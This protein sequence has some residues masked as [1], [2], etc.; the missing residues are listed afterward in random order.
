MKKCLVISF[1]LGERRK[2]PKIYDEDRLVLIKKQIHF[3]EKIKHDLTTIVFSFNLRYEDIDTFNQHINLIP[4][5]IQNSDVEIVL[6][7]NNGMSYGAWSEYTVKNIEKYDYFIYNEDDYFFIQD[8]F[9]EYLTNTFD[10]YENC[11]YLCSISRIPAGWNGFRKHAG[12]AGGI[13]SSDSIKKVIN[14]FNEFSKIEGNDY[15]TGESL[16]IDFTHCFI[17]E[18]MEIYDVRE[19]YRIPF[20]TTLENEPDVTYFFNYN[21]KD[22][23]IP[24][25]IEQGNFTWDVADLKEFEKY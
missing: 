21:Q 22:L 17:K 1:Y 8:N 5:K 14:Y 23:L 15:K 20:S 18:G 11:G 12:Y 3:L 10:S 25:V 19:K 2:T 7:K 6:R 24:L 9:D 16:Q 4:K 13:T